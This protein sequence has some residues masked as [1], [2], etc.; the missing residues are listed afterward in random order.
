[1]DFLDNLEYKVSNFT[2]DFGISTNKIEPVSFEINKGDRMLVKWETKSL[3]K[4]SFIEG[5][6]GL[7]HNYSGKILVNAQDIRH[8]NRAN[9]NQFRIESSI[10]FQ[11]PALISNLSVYENIALPLIYNNEFMSNSL[12]TSPKIEKQVLNIG[13]EFKLHEEFNLEIDEEI[14]MDHKNSKKNILES[15]ELL[16]NKFFIKTM[17]NKL[18]ETLS[19]NQSKIVS[20]ARTLIREPKLLFL[21]DPTSGLSSTGFD[22]FYD[23]V[24][25]KINENRDMMVI[26][27]TTNPR[28]IEKL[29]CNK[30]ITIKEK[31]RMDN[32]K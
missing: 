11:K 25:K 3:G 10:I 20:F 26:I 32:E 4:T 7:H 13:R 21:D 30:H 17:K 31:L 1:M 18:P 9:K 6:A 2:L 29:N 14:Y 8:F 27:L 19:L 15:H 5:L 16:F 22:I 24:L 28:I 23:V 12:G